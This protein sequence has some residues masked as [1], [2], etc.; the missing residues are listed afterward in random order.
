MKRRKTKMFKKSL[1]AL[2]VAGVTAFSANAGILT[3]S[4][5]ETAALKTASDAAATCSAAATILGVTVTNTGTNTFTDT[6]A[7]D[8]VGAATNSGTAGVYDT[9][10]NTVV[11]T[12]NDVCAVTIGSDELVAASNITNSLEGAQANG[13]TVAANLIAGVGGYTAEDTI[14]I[15]VAG[16]LVDED[17]SASATLTSLNGTPSTFTLLGVVGNDILFTVDTGQQTSR[18]VLALAGL[19]V[20][21]NANVTEL[22]LTA[23]TQNT[24]NVIYDQSP[25]EKVTE[26]EAQYSSSLEVAFDGII[27][28][29]TSRL[30]ISDEGTADA[31][32]KKFGAAPASADEAL[33]E[34]TIIVKTTLETTQGN[35]VPDSATITINGN[36]AW[37]AQLDADDDGLE[38][39]E[40]A[41]A[42]SYQAHTDATLAADGD[43]VVATNGIS[44]NSDL[45]ELTV[46][47]DTTGGG[48]TLDAYHEFALVVPGATGT[49][50]LAEQMFT[51]GIVI[52]DDSAA[53]GAGYSATVVAADT[54]LGE[55]ELN[56][57]VVTIPYM[58]FDDNTAV[59]MR[60]TNTGVQSGDITVRYML[61]GTSTNW[62]DS[63][64]VGS[65]SRGVQNI[66]DAVINAIKTDA[67]VDAGKV[68]IE[69]TTNVP[70]EDVTVYAGF[71]VKDE[72]DRGFV[73]TFGQHGSA[74]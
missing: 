8:T 33:N 57:S 44:I 67:G 52:T 37:M 27:D 71:R 11:W 68:A 22:S 42:I 56:G 49:E 9:A 14:R 24:A 29:A 35:L 41:G 18:E 50:S 61:E 28:V 64:V 62:S 15:S 48:A 40:L 16:G 19:V 58:P 7:A 53:S 59:I 12:A 70:A 63:I 31:L 5:T 74:K 30:T 45:D 72:N 55:W 1:L 65:S 3:A 39:T 69:I 10:A 6:A 34:D 38:S 43:D 4:I 23:E 51:G 66:R 17:A 26:L 73:G 47:L 21:P 13:V 32:N 36:F 25:S 2:S 46:T 54:A 60:H 20:T